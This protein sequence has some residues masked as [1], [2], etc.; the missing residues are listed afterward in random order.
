MPDCG[1][2]RYL[3]PVEMVRKRDLKL[4]FASNSISVNTTAPCSRSRPVWTINIGLRGAPCN[5][6]VLGDFNPH[7]LGQ[8][9]W[10]AIHVEP[11]VG[12]RQQHQIGFHHFI[13][14][15]KK[16]REHVL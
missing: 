14:V 4:R 8:S 10:Q 15:N 6:R 11:N 16:A 9:H 12:L 1:W 3:P 13:E 5:Q 7:A 2:D